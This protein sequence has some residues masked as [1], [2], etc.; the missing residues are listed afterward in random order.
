VRFYGTLANFDTDTGLFEC[1]FSE[2]F[3]ISDKKLVFL[4]RFIKL[5]YLICPCRKG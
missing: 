1:D 4:L 2:N 5:L 3:G